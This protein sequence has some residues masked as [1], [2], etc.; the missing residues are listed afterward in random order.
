MNVYLQYIAY[1][2]FLFAAYLHTVVWYRAG[3]STGHIILCI[4]I[5]HYS[6][7]FLDLLEISINF[8][9]HFMYNYSYVRT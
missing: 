4:Y 8:I 2:L 7:K 1:I 5:Y 6:L 9:V 3:K